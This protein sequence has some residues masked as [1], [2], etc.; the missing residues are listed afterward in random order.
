[1]TQQLLAFGRR[2]ILQPQ[3]TNLTH[4]IRRTCE[5]LRR[6]I[7][8][9]VTLDA[10]I[11]G[12]LGSVFVDRGQIERVLMNLVANAI[13]AMP[14]GGRIHLEARNV[15]IDELSAG[16]APDV[17]P[18]AYVLLSVSDTGVGMDAYTRAHVFEPFFTTKET[19]KATG[20]GLAMVYGIVTQSGGQVLVES[21]VGRGTTFLIY[22]PRIDGPSPVS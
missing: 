19:G 18:G 20:M 13:E 21:E 14:S 5:M 10:E 2:Q 17:R 6:L 3:A 16:V 1:M 15:A 9:D 12:A 8:T 22:L 4:T 11:A 7:G